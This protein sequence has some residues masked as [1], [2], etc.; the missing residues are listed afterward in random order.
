MSR[1]FSHNAATDVIELTVRC[2]GDVLVWSVLDRGPGLTPGDETFIFTKFHRGAG[3]ASGGLGLG[4]FSAKKLADLL[5]GRLSAS[6]RQDGGACCALSLP[7]G[8]PPIPP[9]SD[10]GQI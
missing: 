4:L 5:G 10:G 2:D 7:I 9:G 3:H 6:N 1:L 8:M